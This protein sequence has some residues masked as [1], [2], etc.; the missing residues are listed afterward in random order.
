VVLVSGH[1]FD[2]TVGPPPPP[3][4]VRAEP[5]TGTTVT[6]AREFVPFWPMW[7]ADIVTV[8]PANDRH[9]WP[10]EREQHLYAF[11]VSGLH[12]R[13]ARFLRAR[14]WFEDPGRFDSTEARIARLEERLGIEG[15]EQ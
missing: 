12:R 6:L 9:S 3:V 4:F 14:E 8:V 15:G 11:T 13:V 1:H 10:S 2:V 7:R 5:E